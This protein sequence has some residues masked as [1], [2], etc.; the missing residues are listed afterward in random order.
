MDGYLKTYKLK[1]RTIGP[2]FIG[3]GNKIGKKEYIKA[4]NIAYVPDIMKMYDGLKRMKLNESFESFYLDGKKYRNSLS[5]WMRGN[6]IQKRDYEPWISYSLDFAAV[7]SDGRPPHEIMT[8]IKD[9]YGQPYVPGSSV[10][11]AIRTALLS[12]MLIKKQ[13]KEDANAVQTEIDNSRRSKKDNDKK[14]LSSETKK[15]EVKYFNKLERPGTKTYDAVNDM[16]SGMIISD[17]RPLSVDDLILCQK[18]DLSTDNNESDLPILRECIRPGV[19]IECTL[20]VDASLKKRFGAKGI[21]AAVNEMAGFYNKVFRSKFEVDDIDAPQD[22]IIYLGGGSGYLTK[23]VTYP[24]FGE[25]RGMRNTAEIFR[26]TMKFADF[27][28]HKHDS[29]DKYGISPHMC[30]IT[31]CDGVPLEFGRCRMS[32]SE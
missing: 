26:H 24:L 25:K 15:L 17:S 20:T 2:V 22:G 5:E 21:M 30:K 7:E 8:F 3:S 23:T 18:V 9:A 12:G 29:D 27:K 16:M 10:K 6:N 14:Y 31:Y 11:G 19:D 1:F 32:I 4:G 13:A 28:K